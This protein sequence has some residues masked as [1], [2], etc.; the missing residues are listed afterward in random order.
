[1]FGNSRDLSARIDS[2]ELDVS[3]DS[4]LVLQGIRPAG[5]PGMPEAGLMPILRKLGR[6]GVMDMLRISD[7]RMSGTV[8]GTIVLHVS[9]ES[10]DPDSF[11]G[12]VQDGDWFTCSV[13]ESML[14]LY[15]EQDEIDRRIEVRNE[16]RAS[17]TRRMAGSTARDHGWR[18]ILR[19][20]TGGCMRGM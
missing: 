3:E 4:V 1:M 11:L 8:R 12:I 6:L 15:V 13:A 7:R 10:A 5:N 2:D 17:A 18:G 19:G 20:A 14:R 16:E 9:P